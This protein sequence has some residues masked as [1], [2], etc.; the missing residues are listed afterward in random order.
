MFEIKLSQGAKPGKGGILP[1]AKVTAE[2]AAIRGIPEGKDSISPN[3]HPDIDDLD[4]LLDQI[5]RIRE[6]TGKP[7]GFKT[8]IGSSEVYEEFFELIQKRG[9]KS[10]PDFI[11]I[12]GGEGGTGAAPMPLID[13]VGMPLRE[14][15]LR[16]VDMRDRFGLKERIR[17][18][19]S[20][21]LVNPSDVAWA[22][23]AGADFVTTARG[24]MF[25]L[26][27]IQAL[28]CNKNTCPTGVTTHDPHLQRGLVVEQ[29]YLKVA[30]YAKSIIKE[31]ETI[32]HSVGVAEPRLMRRRHVRVVQ[33]NGDSVLLRK[34]RPSWDPSMG[35]AGKPEGNP[36]QIGDVM[37]KSYKTGTDK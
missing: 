1:A 17:I 29:K 33:A 26:G 22:I 3:R 12:D 15:L 27:C 6:L 2:I 23:C 28:K 37:G 7:V 11:T 34:I 4:D 21:K 20:G 18:I 16:M 10:A 35:E 30:H 31:V 32:A 25:S 24:F 5:A 36:V 14:A 19:A 13:L 9:E 8:V